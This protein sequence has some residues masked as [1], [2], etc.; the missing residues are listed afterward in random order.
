MG[1]L[2]AG[3]LDHRDTRNCINEWAAMWRHLP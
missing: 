3:L 1:D 2:L